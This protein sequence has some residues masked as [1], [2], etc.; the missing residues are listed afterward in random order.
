LHFVF[1][2]RALPHSGLHDK[3]KALHVIHRR[4][5]QASNLQEAR[6]K[7]R[8]MWI[9]EVLVWWSALS[10]TIINSHQ[11]PVSGQACNPLDPH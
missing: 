10:S 2:A 7:N 3:H 9:P 1:W 11:E 8:K 4:G 6:V 5:G